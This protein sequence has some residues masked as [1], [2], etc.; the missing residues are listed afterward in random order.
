MPASLFL[1]NKIAFKISGYVTLWMLILSRDCHLALGDT[2]TS[3]QCVK[4]TN[5]QTNKHLKP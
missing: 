5:Q 1:L 4:K 2:K 3:D